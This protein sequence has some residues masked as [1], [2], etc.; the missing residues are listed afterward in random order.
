MFPLKEIRNFL[1][2]ICCNG[3][4][5]KIIFFA[6]EM[7]SLTNYTF[8]IIIL[9]FFWLL[10]MEKK[11]AALDTNGTQLLTYVTVG[12]AIPNVKELHYN[13]HL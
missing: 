4:I 6:R 3:I 10:E 7:L 9:I 12:K 5:N 11:Y 1:R 8:D 13:S 2:Y